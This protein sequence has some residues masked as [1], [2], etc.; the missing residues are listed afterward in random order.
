LG[1]GGVEN[2]KPKKQKKKRGS[3]VSGMEV[4]LYA[5]AAELRENWVLKG[6]GKTPSEGAKK[7]GEGIW[8]GKN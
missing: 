8:G 4:G 7:V 3:A 1:W 2:K 6:K 5:L